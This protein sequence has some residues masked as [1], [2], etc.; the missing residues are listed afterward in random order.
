MPG[1][2]TL[3][4]LGCPLAEYPLLAATQ[5]T[6]VD[7]IYV[8]TDSQEIMD[9]VEDY[10]AHIIKRPE[11]LCTNEALGEDAYVHA[12]DVI[13]RALLLKEH[14]FCKTCGIYRHHIRRSDPS[15]RGVNISC[16]DNINICDYLATAINDEVSMSL[17]AYDADC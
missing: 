3:D 14:Y 5:A 10:N 9:L 15:V 13:K 12:H 1:K 4:V 17:A 7:R 8:S 6:D 16:I 11:Y 2:N